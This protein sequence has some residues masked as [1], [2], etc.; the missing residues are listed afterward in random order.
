MTASASVAMLVPSIPRHYPLAD[1]DRHQS[2]AS[3][4]TV[5]ITSTSAADTT[6]TVA[7]DCSRIGFSCANARQGWAAMALPAAAM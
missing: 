2:F 7:A 6:T 1:S 5:T 4:P 3:Q